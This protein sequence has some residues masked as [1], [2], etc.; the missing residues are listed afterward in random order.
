MNI[1]LCGGFYQLTPVAAVPLSHS[2]PKNVGQISG[3]NAYHGFDMTV[4]LST[5]A[6][7]QGSDQVAFRDALESL[8]I[9]TIENPHWET[10]MTRTKYQLPPQREYGLQGAVHLFFANRF[11]REHNHVRLRVP[12]PL[13]P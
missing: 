12:R 13:R 5:I 2:E 9:G 1:I 11:V 8:R 4:T 7:Q 10:L 3:L 6:R